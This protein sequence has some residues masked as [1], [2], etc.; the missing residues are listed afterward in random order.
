MTG[1]KKCII[2]GDSEVGKTTMLIT[3]TTK[4]FPTEYTPIVHENHSHTITI[5]K[6]SY[7]LGTFDTGGGE[8]YDRLR[9]LSYPQTDVFLVCFKVTRVESFENVRRK[10]VPEIQHFCPDAPFLVVGTQI[11][12]RYDPQVLARQDLILVTTKEGKHL[13]RELGAAKYVECS[14]LTQ[15]GL[16]DVFREA[17]LATL[18][19]PITSPKR[20]SKGFGKRRSRCIVL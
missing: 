19:W 13:A 5:G 17:T 4:S 2:I 8:D 16:E 20:K 18:K 1:T 7:T 12:L 9:P 10:W 11:D 3:Y 14:S 6:D 15:E